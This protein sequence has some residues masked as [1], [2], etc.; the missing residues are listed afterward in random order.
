MCSVPSWAD[1]LESELR[2]ASND[3]PEVNGARG[4]V[5]TQ[6]YKTGLGGEKSRS[7]IC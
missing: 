1:L 6:L 3:G 7:T 5:Q 4:N 2:W